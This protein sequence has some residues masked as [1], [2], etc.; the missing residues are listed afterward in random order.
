MKIVY[1][2]LLSFFIASCSTKQYKELTNE[3]YKNINIPKDYTV[4]YCSCENNPLLLK[5][6]KELRMVGIKVI[7]IDDYNKLDEIK[8]FKSI[9][10]YGYSKQI[11]GSPKKYTATNLV[12]R[13]ESS[14]CGK[15][16]RVSRKWNELVRKTVTT[17]GNSIHNNVLIYKID[18]NTELLMAVNSGDKYSINLVTKQETGSKENVISESKAYEIV[19]GTKKVVSPKKKN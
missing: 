17:S 11:N 14:E 2:I 16:C 15:G 13:S 12:S 19:S 6:I 5:I 1:F 9:V 4:I 7:K 3:K 10:I 18:E 8:S